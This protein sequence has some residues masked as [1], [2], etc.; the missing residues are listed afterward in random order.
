[1]FATMNK[2]EI[3]ESEDRFS[4]LGENHVVH[5]IPTITASMKDV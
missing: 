3:L 5:T 4:S 2:K 1:M